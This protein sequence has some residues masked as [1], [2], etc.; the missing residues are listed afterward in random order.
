MSFK[1]E[2]FTYV[3]LLINKKYMFFYT[4]GVNL[5]LDDR[6]ISVLL[7]KYKPGIYQ[8]ILRMIARQ[9]GLPIQMIILIYFAKSSAFGARFKC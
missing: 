6:V 3:I 4:F 8:Q 5:T 7:I 9:G 1:T 2:R